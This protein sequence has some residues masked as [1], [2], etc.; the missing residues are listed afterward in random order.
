MRLA[1]RPRVR[2]RGPGDL[3]RGRRVRLRPA[4][5]PRRGARARRSPA[6]E[7]AGLP[8]IQVSP[9]QGK[10]LALLARSIGARHGARVRHPRR[11]QHDLARPGAA[12]RRPPDHARGRA[13][14]RGGRARQLERAGLAEMVESASARRWRRCRRSRRRARARSTSSSSTPTRSNTPGYFAWSLERT[15]PGGLIVADNVD[16][17]RRPGR[18]GERRPGD[19]RPAALPRDARRRAAGRGDDDPDRRR[20]GLRRLHDRPGQVDVAWQEF[21]VPSELAHSR[22]SDNTPRSSLGSWRR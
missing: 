3:D 9:P 12:R 1:R 7:E 18:R 10:L 15:R 21:P 8:A 14:L 6:A 20:Q 22:A 11:L 16:P 4:G 13:R 17:R 19:R 2:T 5:A